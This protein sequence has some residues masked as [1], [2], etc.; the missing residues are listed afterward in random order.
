MLIKN[1]KLDESYFISSFINRLREE[2]KPLVK[3]FKPETLRKTFEIVELKEYSLEIQSKTFK[4]QGKT[5]LEAK[6]GKYK[7]WGGSHNIGK[8]YRLPV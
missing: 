2:V 8:S 7:S 4:N 6:F 3:M 1:P 5:V